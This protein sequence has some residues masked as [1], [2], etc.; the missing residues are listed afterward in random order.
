[1]TDQSSAVIPSAQISIKNVAT[2][3]TRNIAADAAGFYL[4]PNC[5]LWNYEITVSAPGSA[6]EVR[7]GVNLEVGAQQVL[8]ITMQVGQ[9]TEK[10]QV[11]KRGPNSSTGYIKHPWGCEFNHGSRIAFEWKELDWPGSSPTGC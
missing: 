1:V 6:T 3:V 5:C 9:V 7:T 8:N 4:R 10:I 2:G 11:D